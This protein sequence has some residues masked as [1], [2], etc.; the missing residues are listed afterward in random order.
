[1][2]LLQP[3]QQ[4][5]LLLLL[6]TVLVKSLKIEK[7]VISGKSWKLIDRFTF[8]SPNTVDNNKNGLFTF[9][10]YHNNDNIDSL[11]LL[12]YSYRSINSFINDVKISND[13][14]YQKCSNIMSKAS[15]RQSISSLS[16][17]SHSN[18]NSNHDSYKYV[19]TISGVANQDV[20]LTSSSSIMLWVIA[21]CTMNPTTSA[22]SIYN[23]GPIDIYIS[24]HCYHLDSSTDSNKPTVKEISYESINM[25]SIMII[26]FVGHLILVLAMSL[27]RHMLH[28]LGKYHHTVKVLHLSFIGYLC[29]Y[30][31]SM[32]YWLDYDKRGLPN[33]GLLV[34]SEAFFIISDTAMIVFFMLLS[35]GWTIVRRKMKMVGRMRITFFT[36]AYLTLSV[37]AELWKDVTP[38]GVVINF[39]TSPPG[40]LMLMLLVMATI[41][42]YSA[43]QTTITN[44][45]EQKAFF[46][47]FRLLALVYTLR[48]PI[49]ELIILGCTDISSV[50]I[51][52]SVDCVVVFIC[53]TVLL[54]VFHPHLFPEQFPFH[55]KLDDMKLYTLEK[56]EAESKK[57]EV[58]ELDDRNHNEQ[59]KVISFTGGYSNT[60]LID[61][62]GRVKPPSIF[63]R[64]QLSKLKEVVKSFGK[65]ILAITEHQKKMEDVLNAVSLEYEH[66]N[67]DNSNDNEGGGKRSSLYRNIDNSTDYYDDRNNDMDTRA[68]SRDFNNDND[69]SNSAIKR[70]KSNRK[71]PPNTPKPFSP[72]V[73]PPSSRNP[74][75]S[76]TSDNNNE[77]NLLSA[78]DDAILNR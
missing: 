46:V 51:Y 69:D 30:F 29:R 48:L 75:L 76:I 15:Y 47:R 10:I 45:P 24:G 35:G 53:Q 73:L 63:D 72:K 61:D 22:S 9:D 67:T 21:S 4:L 31:F 5:P 39:Y 62:M 7:S 74:Y 78:L 77:G 20:L 16:S 27:V 26:F 12:G 40:I 36:A 13:A 60:E 19:D 55:A 43:I 11:Y 58:D 14:I 33:D 70:P 41:R 56:K 65:R 6:L 28:K 1:M 25:P 38:D 34:T 71:P 44:Y 18:T 64:L 42:I 17:Y 37:I 2:L 57:A 50:E 49:V 52:S 32:I 3:L 59:P 8:I 54:A 68:Y 66:V 23:Q